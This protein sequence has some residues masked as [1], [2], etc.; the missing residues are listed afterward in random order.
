MNLHRVAFAWWTRVVPD[1]RRGASD[2]NLGVALGSGVGPVHAGRGGA[3]AGKVTSMKPAEQGRTDRSAGEGFEGRGSG[4]LGR[5]LIV[6]G[7][8]PHQ[9]GGSVAGP[10]Q[11]T[12]VPIPNRH[13]ASVLNHAN[14]EG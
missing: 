13:S 9:A 12:A 4:P 11:P 2:P 5:F 14:R 10:H 7:T 1:R 8:G 6:A 3:A